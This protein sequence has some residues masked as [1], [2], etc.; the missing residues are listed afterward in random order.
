MRKGSL[1]PW[2]LLP[3]QLRKSGG[4]I[5][6]AVFTKK[7]LVKSQ[8]IFKP[9]SP[10]WLMAGFFAGTTPQSTPPPQCRISNGGQGV[11]TVLCPP[12][13]PDVFRSDIF[14]FCTMKSALA[15]LSLSQESFEMS[16][17]W[18]A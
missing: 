2:L 13:W 8:P 16:W 15:S 17:D 10:C 4:K 7:S 11:K 12:G 14:L 18:A 1:R 6:N 9:K 5:V 3:S